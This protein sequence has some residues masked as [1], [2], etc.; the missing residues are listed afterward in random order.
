MTTIEVQ[1]LS[2]TPIDTSWSWQPSF[3]INLKLMTVMFSLSS[4][5]V[6]YR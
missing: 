3:D 5:L 1:S 4:V 2:Q 6:P